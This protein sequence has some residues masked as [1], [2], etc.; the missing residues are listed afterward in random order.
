MLAK[1]W[2]VVAVIF[3]AGSC[4][5]IIDKLRQENNVLRA[6]LSLDERQVRMLESESSQALFQAVDKEAQVIAKKIEELRDRASVRLV[7]ACERV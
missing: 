3:T 4:R 2:L 7:F 5:D 1:V 6:E